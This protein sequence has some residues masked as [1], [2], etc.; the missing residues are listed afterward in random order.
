M[1]SKKHPVVLRFEG[2]DPRDIGGYEAHRY[3]KGGDLGHID[4][5]KP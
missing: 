2:M 5:N 3:R 4:R 1:A